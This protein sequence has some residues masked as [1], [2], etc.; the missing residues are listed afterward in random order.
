MGDIKI[1]ILVINQVM[2]LHC[3]LLA[4]HIKVVGYVSG[5]LS[6]LETQQCW[7][8]AIKKVKKEIVHHCT[9]YSLFFHLIS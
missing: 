1:F 9:M 4:D 2:N 8:H 5:H 6:V 3:L 7:P